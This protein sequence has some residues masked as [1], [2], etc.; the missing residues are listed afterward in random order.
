[1]N[2]RHHKQMYFQANFVDAMV[3]GAVVVIVVIII[4]VV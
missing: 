1:M 2:I 3:S 4:V